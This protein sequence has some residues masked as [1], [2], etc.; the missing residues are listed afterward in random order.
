MS[1][2]SRGIDN[3]KFIRSLFIVGAGPV[4]LLKLSLLI[5]VPAS[6]NKYGFQKRC[7]IHMDGTLA[8]QSIL[9]LYF[10]FT[11]QLY[12]TVTKWEVLQFTMKRN[13]FS[14]LVSTG[15]YNVICWEMAIGE[16]ARSDIDSWSVFCYYF[17]IFWF[18]VSTPPQPSGF[19]HSA[20][21]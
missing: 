5:E 18:T 12:N 2:N 13:Q 1:L 9:Q 7:H 17:V 19:P 16:F 4:L 11:F 14:K 15:N 10:L 8:F 6:E 21:S 20:S 3:R